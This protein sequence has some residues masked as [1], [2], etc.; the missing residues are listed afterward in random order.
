MALFHEK[1]SIVMVAT[2]KFGIAMKFV[3]RRFKGN[4]SNGMANARRFPLV[5]RTNFDGLFGAEVEV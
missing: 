1:E 4:Q 5:P 3:D 2:V